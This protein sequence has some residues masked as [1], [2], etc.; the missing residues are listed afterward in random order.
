MEQLI[1]EEQDLL[2]RDILNRE[3]DMIDAKHK[4]AGQ[5]ERLRFL[6]N[7]MMRTSNEISAVVDTSPIDGPII[8]P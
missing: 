4:L 7:W 5:K 2:Q 3:L 1:K 8:R 6:G